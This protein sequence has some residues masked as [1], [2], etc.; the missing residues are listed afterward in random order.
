MKVFLVL[1]GAASAASWA[2]ALS[3]GGAPAP[4][5]CSPVRCCSEVMPP[6]ASDAIPP[7]KLADA[8]SREEK[9][10]EL[11]GVLKGCSLYL[12]GL[13]VKKTAVGRVL[14]RRLGYRCYD[15]GTLMASTYQTL[16]GSEE[17]TSLS[18]LVATEPLADVEQLAG[19]VLQQVQA[20]T[21]SVIVAW[22]G[23]VSTSDFAIMQQGIVVHIS[24]DEPENVALP[25]E[26]GDEALE[27]WSA[28]HRQAD[29]TVR[30]D[31]DSAADDATFLAVDALL[32]FVA[33]NPSKSEAWKAEADAKLA[34]KDEA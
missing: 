12:T 25:A 22:D 24:E 14:A 9:A 10:K 13:G 26:G 1:L 29:V 16:S 28:G 3:I 7:E 20:A 15:V 2:P 18:Q 23:S 21:R 31:G 17:A 30:V 6:E 27:S 33:A 5:R 11:T 8:W 32:D 4:C 34:S 19:A